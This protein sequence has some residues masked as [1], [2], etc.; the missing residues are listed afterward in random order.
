M[1]KELNR[2]KALYKE[3]VVPALQNEFGYK[4]IN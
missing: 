2:I 4:N 1:A 3:E